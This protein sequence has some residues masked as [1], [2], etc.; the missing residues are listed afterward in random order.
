VPGIRGVRTTVRTLHVI[1]VAALYGGH[2]YGVEAERLGPALLATVATGLAFAGLEVARTPIWLVQVRGLA[3][4]AKIGLAACVLL[5]WDQRVPILSLVLAIGVVV[6]HMPG[7][8][9]YYSV[10]H[11]REVGSQEKG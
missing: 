3:T 9:R 10:L 8:W 11:G 2:V 4:F 6:S 1:A 7:R 5:L